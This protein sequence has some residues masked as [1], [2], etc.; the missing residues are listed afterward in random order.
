MPSALARDY[1]SRIR[2]KSTSSHARQHVNGLANVAETLLDAERTRRVV[3]SVHVPFGT[4]SEPSNVAA[5]GGACPL[6]FRCVG[7]DRFST[8]GYCLPALRA[9]LD[10][11]LRQGEKL[12]SMTEGDDWARAEAPRPR[13]IAR[14]RRLVRITEDEPCTSPQGSH[15][16]QAHAV[17]GRRQLGYLTKLYE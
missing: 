15:L 6:R 13:G 11:L 17:S 1:L 12:R 7:C 9:Y 14:V 3:G 4:C 16:I 10:G 8:D 2:S 5:G